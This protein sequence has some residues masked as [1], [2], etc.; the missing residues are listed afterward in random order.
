[1]Q[2]GRIHTEKINGPFLFKEGGT[3]G[4]Y[5]AALEY[6]IAKGWVWKHESGTYVE[7]QPG[8]CGPVRLAEQPARLGGRANGLYAPA[9]PIA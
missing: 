9:G 7:V 6:A 5:G 4:E 1:V 8:R 3:P 2:D